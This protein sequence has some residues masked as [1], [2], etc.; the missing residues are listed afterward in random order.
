[1]ISDHTQA[2]GE[3]ALVNSSVDTRR[4][5][6]SVSRM[7]VPHGHLASDEEVI[8]KC[9]RCESQLLILRYPTN[10]VQLANRLALGSEQVIFQ[11]DTLVYFA[12]Q[13]FQTT[14][15]FRNSLRLFLRIIQITTEPTVI[16]APKTF[17]M[18]M[19]NGR[20]LVYLIQKNLQWLSKI[21][22]QRKSALL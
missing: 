1:M 21:G 14:T 20:R 3:L 18:D 9:R 5:N 15:R 2:S 17:E 22:L 4:F 8:E 11:A 7:N 19:L 16:F 10:R 6:L 12:K 13:M